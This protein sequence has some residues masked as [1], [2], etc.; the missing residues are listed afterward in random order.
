MKKGRRWGGGGL[1]REDER[2]FVGVIPFCFAFCFCLFCFSLTFFLP[3][4]T[5]KSLIR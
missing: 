2:V 5:I 4:S 3:L 1:E